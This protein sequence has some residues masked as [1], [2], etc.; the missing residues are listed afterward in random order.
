MCYKNEKYIMTLEITVLTITCCHY[1]F[2]LFI[3]CLCLITSQLKRFLDTEVLLHTD[4]RQLDP[5]RRARTLFLFISRGT[6]VYYSTC[7]LRLRA[8]FVLLVAQRDFPEGNTRLALGAVA[9][10]NHGLCQ[11]NVYLMIKVFSTSYCTL[12]CIMV[13]NSNLDFQSMN[14]LLCD[15]HWEHVFVLVFD[16]FVCFSGTN[17][18]N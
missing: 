6:V 1:Y 16:W 11:T 2:L 17:K 14:E 15:L 8:A 7:Y 3:Y 18:R 12:N 4:D 10:I 5:T 9:L 13:K